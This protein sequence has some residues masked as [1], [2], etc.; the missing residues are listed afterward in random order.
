MD[1]HFPNGYDEVPNEAGL[2]FYDKVFDELLENDIEPIVTISHYE[3]PYALSDK[4][5]TDRSMIDHYLKY[6]EVIFRRYKGKVRYW[7]TFNEINCALVPFGI[8][9]ACGVKM[10]FFAPEKYGA[11]SLSGPASSVRRLRSGSSDGT[12]HRSVLPRRVHDRGYGQLPA[13]L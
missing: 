4:G 11:A 10:E 3:P 5:W 9:T 8:M 1:P 7:M 12:I 6:C 2:A 13:D